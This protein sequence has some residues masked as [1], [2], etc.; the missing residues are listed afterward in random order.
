MCGIQHMYIDFRIHTNVARVPKELNS[1]FT[2]MHTHTC[3]CTHTHN[4][5]DCLLM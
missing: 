2:H 4:D 1:L 5:S 3:A